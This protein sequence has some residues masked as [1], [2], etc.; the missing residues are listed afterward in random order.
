MLTQSSPSKATASSNRWGRRQSAPYP[1]SYFSSY[2]SM[3]SSGVRRKSC[4]AWFEMCSQKGRCPPSYHRSVQSVHVSVLSLSL[5]GVQDAATESS[6][7]KG[8]GYPHSFPAGAPGSKECCSPGL[9]CR[10]IPEVPI[11]IEVPAV[12]IVGAVVLAPQKASDRRR[13]LNPPRAWQRP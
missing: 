11:V 8:R 10:P 4:G 5:S 6:N 1:P 12:R 7:T 13:A 3:V 2:F 9:I